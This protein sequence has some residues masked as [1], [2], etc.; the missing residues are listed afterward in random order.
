MVIKQMKKFLSKALKSAQK[1]AYK[2]IY[3]LNNE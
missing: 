2:Y 1:I 3:T